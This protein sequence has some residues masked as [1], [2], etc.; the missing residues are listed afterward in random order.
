MGGAGE[1]KISGA[2][3]RNAAVSALGIPRMELASSLVAVVNK[4]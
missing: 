4:Q 1:G 2:P 3:P